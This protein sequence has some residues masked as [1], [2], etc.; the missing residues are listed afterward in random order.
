VPTSLSA[1]QQD[2]GPR[3]GIPSPAV[4]ECTGI[5]VN[6]N[7]CRPSRTAHIPHDQ[8]SRRAS[9]GRGHA[10]PPYCLYCGRVARKASFSS[11]GTWGPSRLLGEA[12]RN[13][14]MEPHPSDLRVDTPVVGLT[15]SAYLHS[16]CREPRDKH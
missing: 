1:V 2:T 9:P 10:A 16:A 7:P 15:P 4:W 12:A 11:S 14:L 6:R 13:L 3:S 5:L 8:S